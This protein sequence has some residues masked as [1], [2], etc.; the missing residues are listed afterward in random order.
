M[1][2][3]DGNFKGKPVNTGTYYYML[4]Y[5]LIDGVSDSIEGDVTLFR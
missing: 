2:V 5:R 1:R 3:G 4:E